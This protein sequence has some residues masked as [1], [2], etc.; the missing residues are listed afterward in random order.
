MTTESGDKDSKKVLK[1]SR[2]KKFL[3]ADFDVSKGFIDESPYK[4]LSQFGGVQRQSNN[5]K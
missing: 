1:I 5:V 3:S 4:Y 2:N